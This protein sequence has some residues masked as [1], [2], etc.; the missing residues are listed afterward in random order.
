MYS[1]TD[2]VRTCSAYSRMERIDGL[3][4]CLRRVI[5]CGENARNEIP[6]LE[7]ALE[8]VDD[9]FDDI[10]ILKE[11]IFLIVVLQEIARIL[12]VCQSLTIILESLLSA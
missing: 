4:F 12:V 10:R 7:R 9:T 3:K 5:L 8:T 1:R 2:G 11:R 6:N